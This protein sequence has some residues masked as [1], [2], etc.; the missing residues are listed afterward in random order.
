[1][2]S[3]IYKWE[4]TYFLI[5]IYLGGEECLSTPLDLEKICAEVMSAKSPCLVGISDDA[6]RYW[7][8]D[9]HFVVV[10]VFC[11]VLGL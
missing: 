3:E 6:G 4:I 2:G 1:M 8:E 11:Q 7:A 5:L 10:V 9:C